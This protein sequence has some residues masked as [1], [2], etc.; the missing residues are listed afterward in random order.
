MINRLVGR[1]LK[2]SNIKTLSRFSTYDDEKN[3]NKGGKNAFFSK[4]D[5]SKGEPNEPP[6]T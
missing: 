4:K 5:K 2:L 3:K 6:R 1:L